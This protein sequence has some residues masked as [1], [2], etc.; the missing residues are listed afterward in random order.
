M[1]KIACAS[2]LGLGGL[3]VSNFGTTASSA[4]AD[5]PPEITTVRIEK[6]PVICIA[7]QVVEE[8]L[9]AEG[10]TDIRYVDVSEEHV[11]RAD[12]ANMGPVTKMIA[13]GEVDFGRDFAATLILGLEAKAPITILT[14]LHLGCFEV[15]AKNDIQKVSDLRGRIVGY[16]IGDK[17]LL[18]ILANL[19]GIDSKEVIW[20]PLR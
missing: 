2:A 13:D 1:A 14:G 3:V 15:F 17:S 12:A 6:D 8:L 4:D 20:Y 5:P 9:R 16:G 11:R 7:P 18:A 10:F 19:I